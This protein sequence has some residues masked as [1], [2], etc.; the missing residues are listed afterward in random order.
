MAETETL[1]SFLLKLLLVFFLVFANGFFVAAEFS[2]VGVR[3]S[4]VLALLEAGNRRAATLLRVISSLDTYISATQLGITLASLALGWIGEATLSQFLIPIFEKVLPHG[5]A[6]GASHTVAVV[7]AFTTITFLHI[8]LGELA[9][10][11]LALER[12]ER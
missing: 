5:Y 1:F 10:K 4:R 8:V 3:R 9:P 6:V 7:V 11:T 2:L 12:T